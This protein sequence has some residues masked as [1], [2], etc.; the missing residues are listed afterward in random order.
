MTRQLQLKSKLPHTTTTI[1]TKMS[2]LATEYGAI[3]LSQGFPDFICSPKL[4][5]LVHH[6]MKRGDNQYAPMQGIIQLRERIAEKTQA[7]Y[8][9][10]YDPEKEINITAGGTQAIYVAITA[11]VHPGDEVIL[12]APAYDSYAPAVELCGGKSLFINMA[13]P[14]FR[15]DWEEV[16]K[17]ISEKTRLLIV[18]SP[19]N[20][21]GTVL[22][23]E[24][25][26]QLQH[27]VRGTNIAIISDEVY[28]HIIFD[29]RH[30]SVLHYPE[31]A[32]RSFVVFSFGKT[33]HVTGWKLGYVLAPNYLMEEFRKVHQFE[34]FS[35]NR[36]LQMALAD[37]MQ[38]KDEYLQLHDF[39]KKKRDLFISYLK[40]SR[41]MVKPADG[42]YFQLLDY[43]NI[44]DEADT[45]LAVRWTKEIGVASIPISVFYPDKRDQKV[46]RFC[47]AKE[48]DTLRK[49]GELLC[50]I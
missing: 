15:I 48:D 42:T 44:T 49:A 11:L 30:E 37:F 27:I 34:V 20:P 39:Y 17:N 3:N 46:L 6:Y 45:E 35:V 16:R 4:I 12:F 38:Y 21:T 47:F 29:H 22:S 24:D 43:H 26:Q 10:T 5:E 28:E 50:K 9:R 31:L 18:N 23:A 32:E 19:Q 33:Y 7:L 41:F 40:D 1:F 13:A 36:P 25:L 8:N 2:A 14:D